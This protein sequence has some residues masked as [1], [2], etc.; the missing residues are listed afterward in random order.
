M[1]TFTD[2][3]SIQQ[4][5]KKFLQSTI[6]ALVA[7]TAMAGA[8]SISAETIEKSVLQNRT[9]FE[10][11]NAYVSSL[12]TYDSSQNP[13]KEEPSS[14]YPF[15]AGALKDEVVN[16]TLNQINYFRWQFGLNSIGV[17]TSYLYRNQCGAVTMA[18]NGVI[19]HSP[20][21]PAGMD[22]SFYQSALEGAGAGIG[23]SGN[24]ASGFSMVS[25]IKGYIDDINVKNLG[26]RYSLLNPRAYSTSFGSCGSFSTLSMY[27][28]DGS[29]KLS[30]PF[31]AWPSAGY[32]PLEAISAGSDWSLTISSEYT[33]TDN[34]KITLTDDKGNA[35]TLTKDNVYIYDGYSSVSFTLP[36]QLHQY[37][38]GGTNNFLSGKSVSVKVT[39][40]YNTN[41]GES[42]EFNY[43]T[44]FFPANLTLPTKIGVWK[45]EGS[46]FSSVFNGIDLNVGDTAK[47]Y[48]TIEPSDTSDIRYTVT[49]SNPIVADWDNS[50]TSI[51]GL[52]GGTATLTFTCNADPS[53][54]TA[55]TVRVKGPSASVSKITS[56]LYGIDY[57]KNLLWGIY[58]G[59]ASPKVIS[60]INEK[61]NIHIFTPQNTELSDSQ[62][63]GT[64]SLIKLMYNGS[65]L[66]TLTAIVYGDTSGDG[67][68]DNKDLNYLSKLVLGREKQSLIMLKASDMDK[69][70]KISVYDALLLKQNIMG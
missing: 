49:S 47:M 39:G 57:D 42:A 23:Y 56:S 45:N 60:N 15:K 11:K 1:K 5:L 12:P 61:E 14:V 55:V 13:Y 36:E 24:C 63:V 9:M 66:Q 4:C 26:H 7:V 32:F 67:I 30:E 54:S 62:Y 16:D 6:P 68:S 69:D 8:N 65:T 28:N 51:R 52:S 41:L 53:V 3:H 35:Y 70:N 21:R 25:S 43:N 17:N 33:I 2:T 64:G 22:D 19:S 48:I 38:S 40:L 20:A 18:A 34:F 46:Y 50:S 44:K 10:V 37:L 31:Y 59:T 29:M 27:V 58:T